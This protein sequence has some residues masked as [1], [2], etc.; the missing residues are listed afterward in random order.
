M[1][2]SHVGLIIIV[3]ELLDFE[4]E[5]IIIEDFIAETC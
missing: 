3:Q 4:S 5:K 1:K 2:G